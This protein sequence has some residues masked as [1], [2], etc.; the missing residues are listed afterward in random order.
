LF[1]V[2]KFL[3]QADNQPGRRND[4]YCLSLEHKLGIHGSPTAVLAYGDDHG[5]VGPGAIG[6]LIGKEHHGLQYM[7]VMM[8]AA[9]FAVGLQ[10]VAIAERATQ[11]AL[12]YA[13]ERVQSRAIGSSQAA[14]TID[15]HPDVQR[16]LL[17]M[18]GLTE[19]GRAVAYVAAADADRAEH[20]ADPQTRR[21]A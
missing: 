5:E 13:R 18:R 3:L 2:P 20:V 21:E 6:Y 1:L 7:F 11:Q 12:A 10:G 19:A 14:D 8:N 16:M 17:T 9:R 4:V 15:Q